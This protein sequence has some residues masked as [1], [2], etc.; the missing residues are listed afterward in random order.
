E[1]RAS[2][3]LLFV[4]Y[5]ILFGGI[6]INYNLDRNSM[7]FNSTNIPI[8]ESNFKPKFY[9]IFIIVLSIYYFFSPIL[10]QIIINI[11]RN[12]FNFDELN[13]LSE[14]F[15]R[16]FLPNFSILLILFLYILLIE[17]RKLGFLFIGIKK[18]FA[19]SNIKGLI[20]SII[21]LFLLVFVFIIKDQVIFFK[22]NSEFSFTT[23]FQLLL[24]FIFIYIE[25]FF[26]EILYRGWLINILNSRYNIY[27]S[28][29]LAS[30]L[31]TLIYFIEYQRLGIYL[32]YVFI[33]NIFLSFMFLIYK[34]IFVVTSFHAFYKFLKQYVLSIEDMEIKLN[35]IFYTGIDINNAIYNI[36]NSKYSLIII[37]SLTIVAFM[38]YNSKNKNN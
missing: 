25:I 21:F 20:L 15:Y 36:E 8:N 9:V 13:L 12:N 18:N 35:S 19:L 10:S 34:N 14:L 1:V 22:F 32:L 4:Y 37:I 6:M 23:V 38:I 3:L 33:F 26:L 7:D 11:F 29:V 24:V 2:L 27:L 30:L 16:L 5:N 28:L 31:F 17:E